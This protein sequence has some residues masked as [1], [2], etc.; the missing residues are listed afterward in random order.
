MWLDLTVPYNVNMQTYPGDKG[1][2]LRKVRDVEK[3]GHMLS[4]IEMGAHNGTHVDAPAHFIKGGDTIEHMPL[5]LMTGRAVCVS[6]ARDV[7]DGEARVMLA[8]LDPVSN[9][10][11]RLLVQ[12]GVKLLTVPR[13]SVG[14][15]ETH[16]IL[17]GAGLYVC[18]NA[19][20]EAL[21]A[22]EYELI[23]LPLCVNGCEGAPARVLARRLGGIGK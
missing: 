21:N 5:A 10:D 23:C 17:L 16:R 20:V 9:D 7:P 12:K 8:Q 13:M 15:P 14:D 18:E 4:E 19:R 6:N 22:G 2:A 11:A 1:F 3:D